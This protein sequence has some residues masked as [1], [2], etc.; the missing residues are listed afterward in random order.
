[1]TMVNGRRRALAAE[2]TLV[3]GR[4]AEY[5]EF[6]GDVQE[7]RGQAVGPVRDADGKMLLKSMTFAELEDWVVNTLG[8][9][10]Y[11]ARQLWGWMYKEERYASSFEEMTD[12]AKSFRAELE[13]VAR[14]DSIAIDTVHQSEDGTR[15][16]LFRLRS[17]GVVES[18]LIPAEGRSTLCFS[19][20]KGCAFN[21]QVRVAGGA[22][23]PVR[24]GAQGSTLQC[25]PASPLS[26]RRL[27]AC[28]RSS[29]SRAGP[30]S[31]AT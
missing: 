20:Q 29:A 30:A 14:V 13:R 28:A 18:V 4:P 27:V 23:S 11:R 19:S 6:S 24:Q 9:K 3:P 31:P 25:S 7:R 21:C 16:I 26:F 10:K 1:M 8:H 17:G 22:P 2:R 5:P 12:L 15:K